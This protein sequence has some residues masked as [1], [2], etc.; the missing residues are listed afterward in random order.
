V[1]LGLQLSVQPVDLLNALVAWK[2]GAR[3][4]PS[5]LLDRI[6]GILRGRSTAGV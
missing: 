6:E 2:D 3:D 1:V 5:E 4:D